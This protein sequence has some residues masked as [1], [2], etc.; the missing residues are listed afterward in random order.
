M[1]RLL[2]CDGLL[3]LECD[4][5]ICMFACILVLVRVR[6]PLGV[7]E[8]QWVQESELRSLGLSAFVH[9]P[10]IYYFTLLYT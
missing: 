2:V 10:H 6:C 7:V 5:W 8:Y 4:G 1:D 9:E 3:T